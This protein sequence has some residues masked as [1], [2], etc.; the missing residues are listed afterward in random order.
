MT[1]ARRRNCEVSSSGPFSQPGRPSALGMACISA[2]SERT[3]RELDISRA[4]GSCRRIAGSKRA[5]S[6]ITPCPVNYRVIKA[7]AGR[8]NAHAAGNVRPSRQTAL[9]NPHRACQTH[10]ACTSGNS[11][12]A[13]AINVQ[14]STVSRSGHGREPRKIPAS[15]SISHRNTE[16]NL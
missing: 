3:Y 16:P 14:G 7:K 4:Q 9:G 13:T 10:G 1:A 8:P 5:T 12:I 6:R 2:T 15:S 11:A